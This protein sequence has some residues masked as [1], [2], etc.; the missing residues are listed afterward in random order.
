MDKQKSF[1]SMV[2]T[3]KEDEKLFIGDSVITFM[4]ICGSNVGKAVKIH[5]KANKDIPV[6]RV[7]KEKKD[8]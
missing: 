2:I 8:V 6:F 4:R 7:K 1:G 3:F 5:I